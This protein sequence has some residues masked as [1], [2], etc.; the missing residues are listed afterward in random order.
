MTL[1]GLGAVGLLATGWLALDLGLSEI[2]GALTAIGWGLTLMLAVRVVFISG[3]G[4]AWWALLP[5]EAGVS[6]WTCVR[7][8]WVRESINT[9]LPVA[10]L[11]GEFAGARLL[12]HASPSPSL[13]TASVIVDVFIQAS[14]QLLFT[15]LGLGVLVAIGGDWRIARGVLVGVAVLAPALGGFFIA[16]WFGGFG[17]LGAWIMR[18]LTAFGG[19]Q[20]A[21]AGGIDAAI[22][23][24]YARRGGLA[25]SIAIH[26]LVWCVG[27]CEVWIALVFMGHNISW[28]QALVIESLA[29][30]LRAAAF[31]V[32]G[33]LGVQEGAFVALCVA[34]GFPP[35]A[36]IALSLA[37]R[38]CELIPGLAGLALWHF[39]E[40]ALV[41]RKGASESKM[42]GAER[43]V[44]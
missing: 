18:M 30:A 1:I 41:L 35:T 40:S 21:H 13:A 22:K 14:T 4:V 25:E 43:A 23:A 38:A 44:S 31:V 15:L 26:F 6:L 20:F 42:S 2:A 7:L 28:A 29:Q 11:G 27:A 34:F 19:G 24:I 17:W 3:A 32:P 5:P 8:R 33:A 12:A 39:E 37:R 10:Q 16:Q 36:G 9:L